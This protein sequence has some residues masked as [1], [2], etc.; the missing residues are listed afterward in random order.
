MTKCPYVESET[1]AEIPDVSR[2]ALAWRKS[3]VSTLFPQRRPR[4][5]HTEA[6]PRTL[7]ARTPHAE[8]A[9]EPRAPPR[10]PPRASSPRIRRARSRRVAPLK[11]VQRKSPP[12]FAATGCLRAAPARDRDGRDDARL[13]QQG[14]EADQVRGAG[15]RQ[16]CVR[17]RDPDRT[18]GR[19]LGLARRPRGGPF[20]KEKAHDSGGV[21]NARRAASRPAPLTPH[22]PPPPRVADDEMCWICLDETREEL[23]RPCKCPRW[24]R[25]RAPRTP[26]PS[27]QRRVRDA[28]ASCHGVVVAFSNRNAVFQTV[29]AWEP[30][31]KNLPGLSRAPVFFFFCTG[32]R[33]SSRAHPSHRLAFPHSEPLRST[34]SASR[35]GSSSAAASRRSRGV[36]FA[37]RCYPT[38]ARLFSATSSRTTRRLGAAV[39]TAAAAR[40]PARLSV[41]RPAVRPLRRRPTP[42]GTSAGRVRGRVRIRTTRLSRRGAG[43]WTR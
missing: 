11:R 30:P 5:A 10:A 2:P 43:R 1:S 22:P 36:S 17:S 19:R 39:P 15:S 35:A 7:R 24:V 34:A 14:S 27:R 31:S 25:S 6:R 37:S 8:V 23:V 42:R 3:R 20:S 13:P 26:D 9:R 32:S 40:R 38:G 12:S 21:R 4:R 29:R 28:C 16:R 18:L 41:P 33:E